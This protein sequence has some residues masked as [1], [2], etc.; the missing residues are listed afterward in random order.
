MFNYCG[1]CAPN[2]HHP[3]FVVPLSFD[4]PGACCNDRAPSFQ[5]FWPA[6]SSGHR[7]SISW[8]VGFAKT[9]WPLEMAFALCLC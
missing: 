7:L 6:A 2:S 5:N 9:A 1:Y 4:S 3:V 8:W